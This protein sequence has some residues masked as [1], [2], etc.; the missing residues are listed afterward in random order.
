MTGVSVVGLDKLGACLA[1]CLASKGFPVIGVDVSPHTVNLI[2]QGRAP[3]VEPGLDVLI[4][5]N[6]DRLVATTDYDKAILE[7]DLTFIVVPT[8]SEGH[9]GFSLRY[10]IQAARDIGHALRRKSRPPHC[11]SHQHS[12]TRFNPVCSLA[13]S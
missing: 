11:R 3:V 7:S 4:A 6:C 1:A 5:A 12:A 13:C 8:P 10:V 2:N 9:G